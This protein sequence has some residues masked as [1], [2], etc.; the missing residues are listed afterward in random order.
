MF[1]LSLSLLDSLA[2]VVSPV[3]DI[4]NYNTRTTVKLFL[5]IT[6]HSEVSM[7]YPMQKQ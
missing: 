2:R 5:V 1:N 3:T 7:L 6:F 4:V